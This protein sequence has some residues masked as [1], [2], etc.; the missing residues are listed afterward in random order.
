MVSSA[1]FVPRDPVVPQAVVQRKPFLS[2]S[3]RSPAARAI[4]QLARREGATVTFVPIKGG[5]AW[6]LTLKKQ[7]SRVPAAA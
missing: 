4:E 1:G 2:Q 3:P 6:R 5:Y 7:L